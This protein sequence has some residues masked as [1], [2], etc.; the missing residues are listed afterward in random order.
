VISEFFRKYVVRALP[1]GVI[2]VFAWALFGIVSNLPANAYFALVI[3]VTSS[4]F[5]AALLLFWFVRFYRSERQQL[6]SPFNWIRYLNLDRFSSRQMP[7]V[8]AEVGVYAGDHAHTLL[9]LLPLGHLYLVDPW[10]PYNE[11]QNMASEDAK[12]KMSLLYER[13]CQRF[14]G[15]SDITV[16]RQNSQTAEAS[17]PDSFFD[18]VY[19]DGDHS[20]Q[21]TKTDLH[22]WFPKVKPYGV[23]CGDDFI[24]HHTR[25]VGKAV[26]EFA[27]AH[28]LF[29]HVDSRDN[30]WLIIKYP[31]SG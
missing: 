23:L 7:L 28:H 12:R 16:L 3:A 4:F 8:G 5:L 17:F 26:F 14:S 21:A 27:D 20:Y 31:P 2:V 1:L 25:G 30:Q 10:I 19:I 11:T 6:R 15:R 9:E 29:L 22:L 24:G 13:V 18:F